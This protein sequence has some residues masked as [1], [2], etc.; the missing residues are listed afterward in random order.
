M[1]R[2]LHRAS[3]EDLSALSRRKALSEPDQRRL[4]MCLAASPSLVSL[5]QV[6]RDFDQMRTVAADDQALA[7]KLI[8][9]VKERQEREPPRLGVHWNRRTLAGLSAMGILL[10]SLGAMAGLW[11][12]RSQQVQIAVHAQRS[13]WAV[14]GAVLNQVPA[15]PGAPPTASLICP[16]PC[17]KPDSQ[18]ALSEVLV[19]PMGSSNSVL[20]AIHGSVT[21]GPIVARPIADSAS[22]G[23]LF[24]RANAA[25]RRGNINQAAKLYLQLQAQ[26]PQAAE[27]VLSSVLL[28]RIELGHGASSAAL[29]QFDQYLRFAPGGSLAQEA[30]QGRAQALGQLGRRDDQA[31]TYRE[32]LR[33]F[34]ESV[35]APVA[36]EHLGVSQ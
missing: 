33:R 3:P 19:P 2:P 6:G 25:R 24:T 12:A 30:L 4:D 26:Y 20:P 36:R 16:L 34:P 29:K 11:H 1:S 27:A 18:Q 8:R 13:P 35:Y 32:L 14:P 31:A 21:S 28:A 9:V 7:E 15:M 17:D 23:A 22:P 10:I 5:D